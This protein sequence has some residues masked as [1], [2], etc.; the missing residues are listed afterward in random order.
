MRQHTFHDNE[1]VILGRAPVV[2]LLGTKDDLVAPEDNIDLVTGQDFIYL[3][4]PDCGHNTVVEMDAPSGEKI[5]A[6]RRNSRSFYRQLPSRRGRG[7]LFSR[8][9]ESPEA[10]DFMENI[11][12]LALHPQRDDWEIIDEATQQAQSVQAAGNVTAETQLSNLGASGLSSKRNRVTGSQKVTDIAF[13]IHGIR[14]LGYWTQKVAWRI[15]EYG[16]EPARNFACV[17]RS[18]GYFPMWPFLFPA[19]RRQHVEWLVDQVLDVKARYPDATMHDCGHSNGTYLLARALEDHPFLKF[20]HVVFAGSVVRDNYPWREMIDRGQVTGVLN[21]IATADLVVGW[22]PKLFQ[23]LPLI[24]R[25]NDIGGG[26]FDGFADLSTLTK[27]EDSFSESRPAF[28]IAYVRG[29]HGAAIG[30]HSWGGIARAIVDGKLE[31][32]AAPV[33]QN[34]Q[35]RWIAALSRWPVIVWIILLLILYGFLCLTLWVSPFHF[36]A[37]V[38]H[39]F[40][41]LKE[42][43]KRAWI[44]LLVVWMEWRSVRFILLRL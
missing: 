21:Y 37:G 41:S 34:K 24:R 43:D 7:E 10:D 35:S 44:K 36:I 9:I 27:T 16:L 14:D 15:R 12:D 39:W 40:D 38:T 20:K 13:V 11:Q 5:P 31:R 32:P 18:Y 22:F 17:T 4:M 19:R 2:Q 25:L 33:F 26:G 30:E 29:G 8:A 28:Q 6:D 23:S 1:G 42:W 3:E